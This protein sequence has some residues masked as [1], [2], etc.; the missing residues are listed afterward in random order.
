MKG[1][2]NCGNVSF[3]ISGDIP[4]LYQCHCKLC[5]KQSGSTSNTATI[6]KESDFKWVSGTDSISHW[7]KDSGFTSHFCKQCG[8]PVPNRLRE[9]D[10]YWVPMGLVENFDIKITTHLCCSSKA[11]WENIPDGGVKHN[12]MPTDLD[13]FIKSLQKNQV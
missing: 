10:L 9:Y 6:V 12:E 11:N 7:K 4:D 1:S 2:C 13:D 5:Q 3:E 8:C